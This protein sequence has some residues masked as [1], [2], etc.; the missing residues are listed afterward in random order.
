MPRTQKNTIDIFGA[1]AVLSGVFPWL[2]LA[3]AQGVIAD[4]VAS[5]GSLYAGTG[6]GLF[7]V[8]IL[9]CIPP[10]ILGFITL[11]LPMTRSLRIAAILMCFSFPL[12]FGIKSYLSIHF[13]YSPASPFVPL[14]LP[15]AD[16]K[17][18]PESFGF[19]YI[20]TNAQGFE[21]YKHIRSGIV[22]VLLP[23]G[24][25]S[26]GSSKEE[27]EYW[28]KKAR[29]DYGEEYSWVRE[30]AESEWPP[31]K[32]TV[33]PFLIAK[34]EVTQVAWKKVMKTIAW[35]GRSQFACTVSWKL[36]QVFCR[37][38]NLALPTEAQWE[39]A[40][41][42]GTEGAFGGSGRLEDMGWFDANSGNSWDNGSGVKM[43]NRFG[44]YDMHGSVAEYCQ[45]SY[46]PK[47]Y[48]SPQATQKN[49]VCSSAS[50]YHVVRGGSWGSHAWLCRSAA[51]RSIDAA[52]T[53][54]GYGKGLRPMFPLTE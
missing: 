28:I 23:G 31:H 49:P 30:F 47:F 1:I 13:S 32:V 12:Y 17:K 7:V 45:D 42:A 26:M 18:S 37:K 36:C 27:I 24:T 52:I 6:F 14:A 33:D 4:E 11:F 46:E 54:L 39:Y 22:M 19:T 21:E 48:S 20:D 34:Y 15:V 3:F 35:E 2:L 38:A 10:I 44:L 5:T 50:R 25:F 51:R 40:C 53:P 41:R 9:F 8:L 29:A 43:P 16:F